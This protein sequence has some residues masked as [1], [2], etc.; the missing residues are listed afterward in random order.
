MATKISWCDEV[1][2][3]VT[4][5]DP[6]DGHHSEACRFCYAR[7]MANRLK[8]RFGYPRDEPF[9]VTFHPERLDKPSEWIKPKKIFLCSMG[10]LFHD[11]V[12]QEWIDKVFWRIGFDYIHHTF[13]IL[14]KRP[15]RMKKYFDRLKCR[16]GSSAWPNVWSGCTAENQQR[17]DERI[18][19]L[20]KIPA[21]VRFLSL[22]PLLGPIDLSHYLWA[23]CELCGGKGV[24]GSRMSECDCVRHSCMPG[25]T[26]RNKLHWVII[27]GL[28][29]PGNK[30]VPP[31]PEWVKSILEQCDE[32]GVPVFIKE[33]ALYPEVRQDFPGG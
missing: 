9:R 4:G 32:A 2:N 1:W 25:I 14:T 15:S 7:R 11:E 3:V 26:R 5:C 18:P 6:P 20:L 10:D 31:K 16:Y 33:N 19:V 17:A 27:G 24:I 29:L 13:L 28:S 22:E 30:I 8:G 21:A 23:P 12:P